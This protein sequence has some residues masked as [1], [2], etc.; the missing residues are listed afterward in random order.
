MS[1]LPRFRR[2]ADSWRLPL[3]RESADSIA[4]VLL[5]APDDPNRVRLLVRQFRVDPPLLIYAVLATC[6]SDGEGAAS[7]S[8]DDI[9][10]DFPRQLPDLLSGGDAWLDG[11]E[12]DAPEAD[13]A[14]RNADR[15][16]RLEKLRKKFL[17][18]PVERWMSMAEQWLTLVG[19]EVPADW[20]ATWPTVIDGG[21]LDTDA[22]DT[23]TYPAL[24]YHPGQLDLAALS[25]TLRRTRHLEATFSDAI[26]EAKRTALKQFAYGLSHEINN[27]LANISTRAQ[28][29]I[30]DEPDAARR[31]SLQRIVDQAMRAHEMTADLMFYAH[32]PSPRKTSFDLWD[33]LRAVIKQ[34]A[35]MVDGRAIELVIAG[36]ARPLV[37]EA[38][39]GMMTEAVRSLVRNAIEAI[40]C[41]GRVVVDCR[42]ESDPGRGPTALITVCD[43]GPGL[44]DAAVEHAF[45]PYFSGREAGRGLGVGLC[46]VERIATL[47]DG[48]ASL[49]SGP[50]GCVA[51]VRIPK[52][53]RLPD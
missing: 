27:P 6:D 20:K 41:D 33:V 13:A 26:R 15:L 52:K 17:R 35:E 51:S 9:A 46:R 5:S 43:S 22:A 24:S 38:D 34:S 44:S 16:A 18:S 21:P 29:L 53:S 49:R 10:A 3:S 25:R 4:A 28:T 48:A 39:R 19:P 8:V 36:S 11:P 12:A 47:H 7:R 32:P 40:G 37:V 42:S 45:D 31:Q 14:G 2:G 23:A 1:G 50:A 30:R